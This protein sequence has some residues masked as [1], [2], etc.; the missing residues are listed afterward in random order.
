MRVLCM[1]LAVLLAAFPQLGAAQELKWENRIIG[2]LGEFTVGKGI[3]CGFCQAAEDAQKVPGGVTF[4]VMGKTHFVPESRVKAT[5]GGVPIWCESFDWSDG[6][7]V[8]A[9]TDL[10]KD[11]G[12]VPHFDPAALTSSV[13]SGRTS[14]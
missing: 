14:G 10:Y 8:N 4:T 13:P 2:E 3:C 1:F 5:P 12:F 9:E 7:P 6:G 11:C